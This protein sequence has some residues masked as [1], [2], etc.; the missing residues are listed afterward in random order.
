MVVVKG[1]RNKRSARESIGQLGSSKVGVCLTFWG[2]NGIGEA[3]VCNTGMVWRPLATKSAAGSSAQ[4]S[5]CN[6]TNSD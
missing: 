4:F 6:R 5:N 2:G 3:Q 1:L